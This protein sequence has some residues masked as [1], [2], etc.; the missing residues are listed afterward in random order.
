MAGCDAQRL[1]SFQFSQEDQPR[2][3]S[4]YVHSFGISFPPV[5]VGRSERPLC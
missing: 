1:I 4:T 2:H 3:D 5:T